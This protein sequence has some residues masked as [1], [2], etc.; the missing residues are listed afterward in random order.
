[1]TEPTKQVALPAYL[2]R[3]LQAFRIVRGDKTSYVL[4]DKLADRTYDLEQWQFFV[5]EVLPGCE[6]APKLLSVFSDRFGREITEREVMTFFAELADNKLLDEESA[7]HPLLKPFSKQGYALEQGLVKPKSFEELAAKLA[8]QTPRT[9]GAPVAEAPTTRTSPPASPRPTAWTRATP[10]CSS[11]SS[12][13]G[14]WC[15]GS[16]RWSSR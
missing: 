9:A 16:C 8:S 3:R 13:C 6:T 14:Q 5:L 7:K 2:P 4:R 12:R 15:R 10:S 11:S 1:M